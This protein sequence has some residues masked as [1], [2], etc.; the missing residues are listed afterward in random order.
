MTSAVDLDDM[1][2]DDATIINSWFRYDETTSEMA[3]FPPGF[4]VDDELRRAPASRLL[5]RRDRADEEVELISA[6]AWVIRHPQT[7]GPIGWVAGQ[8]WPCHDFHSDITEGQLPGDADDLPSATFELIVAPSHRGLGYGT[9]MLRAVVAHRD[10]RATQ[11]WLGIDVKNTPSRNAAVRAG[12]E[13]EFTT[14]HYKME[15][16]EDLRIGLLK[17][18]MHFRHA[19]NP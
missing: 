3:W 9:A 17:H 15:G 13:H 14:A 12:F 1:T 2:P 5:K 7:E 6:H 11:L 10:L 16:G 8:V 18:M 4:R 19:T